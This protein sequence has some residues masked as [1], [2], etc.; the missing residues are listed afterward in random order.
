MNHSKISSRYAKA[1]LLSAKEKNILDTV[2]KDFLF[3]EKLIQQVPDF[4]YLITDPFIKN[5][6]KYDALFS[7]IGK[8]VT[9]LTL[10]FIKMIFE[11]KRDEFF[12]DIVRVFLDKYRKE[13]G[14]KKVVL[15]LTREIGQESKDNII[16]A[17]KKAYNADVELTEK[18]KP[19]LIGG[20][21]L[22][23]EDLQLDSTVANKL[24]KL[25]KELTST[26]NNI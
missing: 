24:K 1:L 2:E 11:N 26:I 18:I 25:K 3:I 7:I 8:K 20:F 14:I 5:K 4:H 15:T 13:K 12:I 21:I 10:D 6:K 17:V 19:E 9:N 22:R 16:N 23:V